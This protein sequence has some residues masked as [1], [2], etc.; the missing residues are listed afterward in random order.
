MA[1]SLPWWSRAC[2][3]S[4]SL[5]VT[6]LAP[7]LSSFDPPY[8]SRLYTLSAHSHSTVTQLISLARKV[9]LAYRLVASLLVP[10]QVR[11]SRRGSSCLQRFHSASGWS[12][13][14]LRRCLA[15]RWLPSP[16]SSAFPMAV[17]SQRLRFGSGRLATVLALP[18]EWRPTVYIILVVGRA[19]FPRFLEG[20]F[21][22]S[23][24]LA[25]PWVDTGRLCVALAR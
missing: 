6:N 10:R 9:C 25:A 24:F 19:P 21:R 8:P 17:V 4:C 1:S 2:S 15:G 11:R 14:V 22:L 12:S 18:L 13:I 5:P 23:L 7:T 3:C 20:R 16:A